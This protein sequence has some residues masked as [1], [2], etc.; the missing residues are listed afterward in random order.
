MVEEWE[1]SFNGVCHR[2]PVPLRRQDITWEQ[3]F[4]LQVLRLAEAVPRRITLWQPVSDFGKTAVPGDLRP[5]SIREESLQLS[6]QLPAWNVGEEWLLLAVDVDVKECLAVGVW[7]L[8]YILQV[9][10]QAAEQ[11]RPHP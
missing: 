2:H 9:R 6:G 11:D 8:L 3:V 1:P 7:L 10:I 4:R 5:C